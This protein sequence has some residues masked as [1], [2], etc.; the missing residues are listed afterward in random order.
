[1]KDLGFTITENLK[2]SK[3]VLNVCSSARKRAFVIFKAI[4][5]SKM[6]VLLLAY[7]MYV[8]S[9]LESG[10][11]VFSPYSKEDKRRLENVQAMFTKRVFMRCKALKYTD[12]PNRILRK[13][14]LRLDSLALR[15]KKAD[16]KLMMRILK[17]TGAIPSNDFYSFK[18]SRTRGTA[19]KIKVPRCRLNIRKHFFACRTSYDYSIIQNV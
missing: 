3:H 10:S 13:R 18:S 1:M 16:M 17:G 9:I 19:H 11:T 8:R 5:S 7:K 15:R 2:F 12:T 14:E 6:K 4:K